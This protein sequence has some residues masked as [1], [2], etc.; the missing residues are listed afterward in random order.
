M[1]LFQSRVVNVGAKWYDGTN[2]EEIVEF[3]T[4]GSNFST[5]VETITDTINP[6]VWAVKHDGVSFWM[7][8]DQFR[9]KYKLIAQGDG[10]DYPDD[11]R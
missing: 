4:I 1:A 2:A 10:E 8:D 11:Y 3:M 9:A 6:G 5:T 7:L